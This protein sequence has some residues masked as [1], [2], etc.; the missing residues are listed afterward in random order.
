LNR[1]PGAFFGDR[2][3]RMEKR[4]EPIELDTEVFAHVLLVSGEKTTWALVG[5][6]ELQHRFLPDASSPPAGR[7]RASDKTGPATRSGL[8][9]PAA[10][11]WG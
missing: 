1:G 2:V 10:F 11:T 4:D 8:R 3:G 5:I 9:Q 7:I 6:F